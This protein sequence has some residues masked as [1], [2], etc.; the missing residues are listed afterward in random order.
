M[1]EKT[2]FEEVLEEVMRCMWM[3]GY[4][5]NG[6]LLR[7]HQRSRPNY[8]SVYG[9][10]FELT[11]KR[12]MAQGRGSWENAL[13]EWESSTAAGACSKTILHD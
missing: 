8:V 2:G 7:H 9:T 10:L 3:K 11:G 12:R 1:K 13:P 4:G 6:M 5:G